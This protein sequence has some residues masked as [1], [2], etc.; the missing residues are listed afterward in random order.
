M[1]QALYRKWRPRRLGDVV[2]QPHVTETLRTQVESGRLSHAY[3][4]TGTRGTGKTTC[5]KIL[6]KAVN[7][8]HPRNGDPCNVCGTCR[9]IE[10]GSILDILEIDAA[11]NNGVDHIRALRDEAVY[12]PAAARMR[13][14]II[15]EVHMLST[16]AF[17]ALLK[18]LEEPPAHLLF[19]LATTELQKVPATILSRCQ[20]FSFKRILPEEITARLLY[21]AGEEKIDLTADGA[22]L[23][24]RLAD[25]ALRDALSLLDQ[26]A[27]EGGTVDAARV[28]GTLGL[29]GN[30]ETAALL[31]STLAGDAAA[32]LTRLDAL[33]EAG[34]DLRALLG[35][36]AALCR[37]LLVV[38]TAPK[39][40]GAL[41]TG[42]YGD[43]TLSR[44]AALAEKRRLLQMLS[45]LQT[46]QTGLLR[47][48]N[49]RTETE[50]CLL[51]LCDPALDESLPALAARV[52]RLEEGAVPAPVPAASRPVKA[53]T[54]APAGRPPKPEP[55]AYSPPESSKKSAQAK[56]PASG[57]AAGA[58]GVAGV[59][60]NS[61]PVS[62]A[63]IP[64]SGAAA[65]GGD[66][67]PR[68]LA[69][70]RAA[71]FPGDY[72]FLSNP[73]I[74]KAALRDGTLTLTVDCAG[75]RDFLDK[76]SLRD[77]LSS[78]AETVTGAP[79]RVVLKTAGADPL[80]AL[81]AEIGKFGNTKI[82]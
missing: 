69:A 76:A 74:T 16:A 47:G 2:G 45:R 24:A 49:Q 56:T 15:D 79:A 75:N 82:L 34:K 38:K 36:L 31:E 51:Q 28:L 62:S 4:F 41:L 50:L 35:E 78:A 63:P 60:E 30:F 54:P 52:A 42:G 23:L 26:C 46:A 59:S 10:D 55:A 43:D 39:G 6:A 57:P 12:S 61:P 67:W 9:G 33:Y 53:E 17:N 71:L 5:A 72:P 68:I 70:A 48:V 27:A 13:V 65:P 44:L 14:Y 11:S 81:V 66:V 29:S 20:R 73:A 40:G 21:V 8:E 32:A 80:D 64:V 19:I 18:I 37:D 3:L 25:G 1:Y 22:V 77:A 58:A 7:C